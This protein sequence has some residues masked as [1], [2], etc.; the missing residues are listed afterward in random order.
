[1]AITPISL[2]TIAAGTG[3]FVVIGEPGAP[4]DNA[5]FAVAGGDDINN[6]GLADFVVTASAADGALNADADAGTIYVVFGRAGGLSTVLLSDILSGLGSFAI[7]GAAAADGAGYVVFGKSTPFAAELSLTD[8]AA[9]TGGFALTAEEALDRAGSGAAILDLNGD[10]IGDSGEGAG[11]T[12]AAIG[13]INGD[14]FAAFANAG[15]VA[16]AHPDFAR[17]AFARRPGTP[18]PA[19][20]RSAPARHWTI[21]APR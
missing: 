15:R 8:I 13:D 11:T 10:S 6:D 14:D 1:M 20:R 9:G 7:H 19:P 2:T 4:L 3:G 17:P 12:I 5:G 18:A 21:C 16:M